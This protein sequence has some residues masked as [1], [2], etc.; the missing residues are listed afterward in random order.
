L[1]SKPDK[2]VCHAWVL[3]VSWRRLFYFLL[4]CL[5]IYYEK[6]PSRYAQ[7]AITG[8]VSDFDSFQ[9]GVCH[10]FGGCREIGKRGFKARLHQAD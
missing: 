1:L 5:G 7:K 3:P 8:L 4:F 6:Y 9:F 2:G 10:Q